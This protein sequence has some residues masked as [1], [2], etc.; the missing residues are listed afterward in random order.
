MSIVR[1]K[2][3]FS[4]F[5]TLVVVVMPQAQAATPDSN[6]TYLLSNLFLKDQ[7]VLAVGPNNQLQ[8]A[9]RGNGQDQLWKF[10][11][12]GNGHYRITNVALGEGY[13]IDSDAQA[14]NIRPSG[15]YSGQHW[16]LTPTGNGYIRLSNMFQTD[17]KSLDTYGNPPHSPFLGD[18]GNY[19]GQFWK[20]TPVAVSLATPTQ[21]QVLV[22][23]PGPILEGSLDIGGNLEKPGSSSLQNLN[24]PP[25][26]DGQLSST[27][28]TSIN[29]NAA[30]ITVGGCA[31]DNP[32]ASCFS[33]GHAET[34]AASRGAV[35][36]PEPGLA[37]FLAVGGASMLERLY[38]RPDLITQKTGPDV[39]SVKYQLETICS[40]P[41]NAPL[42]TELLFIA[43]Q[44]AIAKPPRERTIDENAFLDAFA[45]Y[46]QRRKLFDAERALWAFESWKRKKYSR[47]VSSVEHVYAMDEHIPAEAKDMVAEIAT[48]S[49]GGLALLGSVGSVALG[50]PVFGAL[51]PYAGVAFSTGV[52]GLQAA[53][54]VL[55]SLAAAAGPASIILF[56]VTGSATMIIKTVEVAEFEKAL[57]T[58]IAE[59]RKPLNLEQLAKDGAGLALIAT[60]WVRA[61][62]APGVVTYSTNG[63]QSTG[64]DCGMATNANVN[65][66]HPPSGRKGGRF[67]VK[68]SLVK[69]SATDAFAASGFKLPA[70]L[71][72]PGLAETAWKSLAI[73][74]RSCYQSASIDNYLKTGIIAPCKSSKLRWT[75]FKGTMPKN[76]VVAGKH[77]NGTDLVVCRTL[78][79]DGWHTGKVWGGKCNIGWGNQER[80]IQGFDVLTAP[81]EDV[82]WVALRK[83]Q[84]L[85]SGT[86]FG[87]KHK[88]G[89]RIAVC[90]TAMNDGNHPGKVWG[91]KCYIGWGRKAVSK[92]NYDVLI[93]QLN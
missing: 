88:N 57:R 36:F 9:K 48:L 3:W 76:A 29:I 56:A 81:P 28:Q 32:P 20:L 87:G 31:G 7:T 33:T 39:Q 12:L 93:E 49:A 46:M 10:K 38:A 42:A 84:E 61:A 23:K 83:D 35:Q 72:Y 69:Y 66:K 19:T 34:T 44:E 41:A 37:A 14:P 11:P 26:I 45:S 63:H 27:S 68:D 65:P 40:D 4:L 30:P 85:P 13:S 22:V 51:F 43:M 91:G 86:I 90:R 6:A 77:S 75:A 50:A 21:E 58:A 78:I 55:S 79:E 70:D 17:A 18:K 24:L 1:D 71:R 60:Y 52:I 64:Y 80:A 82:K 8:M 62:R 67:V 74:Q 16:K 47:P 54:G 92:D 73:A 89:T 15:N 5:I 53:S 2:R 59:A 25:T